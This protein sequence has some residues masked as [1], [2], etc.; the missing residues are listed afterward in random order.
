MDKLRFLLTATVAML[1]CTLSR[2][3]DV[4]A[5]GT[6]VDETGQPVIGA[7]VIQKGTTN[8]TATDLDGNF[9]LTTPAGA[10]LV[11]SFIGYDNVEVAAAPGLR[12]ELLS[13]SR[14][15]EELVVTGYTTQRKADLTGSVAVVDAA[16]LK[17]SAESNPMRSL[18]GRVAGMTIT[19]DGSPSGTATVRMRGIGSF[20]SSQDPLYII[21]GVPSTASLNTLNA[22]DIESMQVLK[23]AAS[24][25]I[26]GSRAANGVI[27]ITTRKGKRGERVKIDVSANIMAQFYNNQTRMKL[28]NTSQYATAMAQAA[29]NDGID[30]VTYAQNYGLNLNAANGFTISAWDAAN[31]RYNTYTVDG[32][33]DGYVNARR[34]MRLSDTDWLDEISRTGLAQIYDVSLSNATDTYSALFSFGYK[35]NKGILKYTDFQNFAAR[36][37]TSYN[38]GKYVTVGENATFSFTDQVDLPESV[39][40]RSVLEEALKMSPTLPVYE[41]DGVTFSGPVGGMADRENP[42]RVL[43]QNRDNRQ[44]MRR[45]FGNAYLDIKPVRGLVFRSNFGL[46]YTQTF[47]RRVA[48]TYHSDVVNNDTPSVTMSNTNNLEWT[49]SNTLTYNVKAWEEHTFNILLGLELN[50]QQ[51]ETMTGY[52]ERFAIEEYDY[53][54]PDA[55]TGAQRATG[56]G[57]GY[58]LVS[59]FGKL[60]Y[61]W[62]DLVLA[63]FTVRRDGS[64]RFGQDNR[65]GTFPAFTLGYR[66]SQHIGAEWLDDLKVRASWGETGNQAINNTA[67]YGL[68]VADY[69]SQRETST[70]YDIRQAGSGIFP[71]GFRASQT[72]NRNLKWETTKQWNF[73]LDYALLGNSLYGNIDVYVKDL[74]DMLIQPNFLGATGEGGSMWLNGPALRN[75][76]MEMQIGY[77]RTTEAGFSYD[78]NLNFDFYRSWVTSLPPTM[79]G[80]YAHTPTQDLVSG[81]RAYGSRAG[82]VVE[83]LFQSQAE[84]EAHNQPG[85][86]LGGLRYKDIDGDG[87]ITTN[88]Q[89]WIY[90]P[91][92]DLNWGLNVELGYKNFDLTM[93][94]QGVFGVDIYNN[95]KYQTDFYALYDPG[96]NKG[97]RML[98]AWRT[99]NTG[100]GIPALSTMSSSNENR[101]SSYYVE[102]GSWLKMRSL[103]V[104]YT[105][106]DAAQAAMRM[107]NARVYV[108]AGNLFTAKSSSFKVTDPENPDWNYPNTTTVSFGLQL[109]F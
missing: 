65:Y 53:M 101:E 20:N 87:A 12:V 97:S 31:N 70:A 91:V 61:N 108:S 41:T 103:Q 38:M 37:N 93:F 72:E 18:Q 2:G 1:F 94:F 34:T 66:L 48:L 33:Y 24:A 5:S 69:G 27:I 104:G 80:A 51:T 16:R 52:A 36:V 9:S 4:A 96:S 76:G 39:N 25:S 35:K 105:L 3:Q 107:T 60:D 7:S 44:K 100:S 89:D 43:F 73:G 77:R 49:W 64:S 50:N 68:Y 106:P 62:R 84:I 57:E 82:Y 78:A 88:D 109:G 58:R 54:W 40:S 95:Q 79:T 74:E 99:N 14:Q 46:D 75:V 17:N 67:R 90:D 56:L 19:T 98:D 13:S 29:L 83:G 8:G 32:L 22:N 21:D 11:I 26:Y 28:M 102:H 81:K 55:S 15:L 45:V 42:M 63:S 30:P 23:D 47:L 86:R 59:Y 92:P 85:G 71:S 6:V 10:T